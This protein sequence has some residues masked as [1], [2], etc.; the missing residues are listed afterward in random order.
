MQLENTLVENALEPMLLAH[1]PFF[2]D[3]SE[4]QLFIRRTCLE[5]DDERV[6]LALDVLEVELGRLHLVVEVGVE[7]VELVALDCLGWRI[8]GVVVSLVVLVPFEAGLH[9]VEVSRFPWS[10]FV[11]LPRVGAGIF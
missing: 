3:D 6:G 8:V 7:D 11:I 4:S 1:V 2:V 10:E 9:R 5:T